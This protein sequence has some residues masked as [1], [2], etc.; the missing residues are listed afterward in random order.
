LL[1]WK[2]VSVHEHNYVSMIFYVNGVEMG[3]IHG[4]SVADLQFPSK[5][6]KK[7]LAEGRVSSHH[8]IPKSGWISHEIRNA[9]D[10]KAVIELF[11]LQY[12]RLM[13]G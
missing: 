12:Q 3:H 7:L 11:R 5:I 13:S 1:G 9:E 4:D 6:S 10:T 8:V 2:G